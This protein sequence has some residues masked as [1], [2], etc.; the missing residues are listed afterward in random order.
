MQSALLML[1]LHQLPAS[2]KFSL[3]PMH[4]SSLKNA[5]SEAR[6]LAQT[7]VKEL[8][9]QV[10]NLQSHTVLPFLQQ[11]EGPERTVARMHKLK[12]AN[13]QVLTQKHHLL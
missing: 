1:S 6:L 12:C 5:S 11:L 10:A 4:D 7:F 13:V 3:Q 8:S 2:C 9:V